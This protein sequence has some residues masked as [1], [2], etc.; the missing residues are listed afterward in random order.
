MRTIILISLI[1]FIV[2]HVHGQKKLTALVE[3]ADFTWEIDSSRAYLIVY[4]EKDSYPAQDA[5]SLIENIRH[6]IASTCKFIGIKEYDHKIHYFIL[7]SRARMSALLGY[8]TNGT[9]NYKQDYVTA[10]YSPTINSVSSNHELF[11]LIAMNL[12]G[13]T[14]TWINEGM[15]VYADGNWR[16][17][18]LHELAR[19][20]IFNQEYIPLNSM[21]KRPRKY[22]SLITYPLLGSFMKFIDQTYGREIT[23]ALWENGRSKI[24]TV[25]GKSIGELEQ[26]WLEMLGTV[27]YDDIEYLK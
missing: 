26:E 22:D 7:E 23:K 9:A 27:S 5:S 6:H 3:N 10:I 14:E 8:E 25:T 18:G 21:S 19:Y 4:F 16:G 12:W 24:K 2:P 17:Y 13:K 11:H 20:L 15:A 1:T